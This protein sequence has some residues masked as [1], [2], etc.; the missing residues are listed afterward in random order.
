MKILIFGLPG[1]GKTTLARELAYHFN[2]PHHN[3]DFYRELHKDWDFSEVGRWRQAE[4]MSKQ[5]GILDFVAPKEEIRQIINA[6]ITIFMDTI[7]KGRYEDTNKVFEKPTMREILT[8]DYRVK[9]WIE[10]NQLHKC[11]E[12]FNPGI[13]GILNFLRLHFQKLLK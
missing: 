6:D 5:V 13:K 11:L 4:R 10:L 12:D 1:S 9:E 3:A 8:V 7:K 2:V